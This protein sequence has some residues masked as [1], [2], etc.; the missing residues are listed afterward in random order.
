M[1][2]DTWDCHPAPPHAENYFQ[3]FATF[4]IAQKLCGD[5][6]AVRRGAGVGIIS[7][8][9][10][11]LDKIP[12]DLLPANDKLAGCL[13]EIVTLLTALN[14]PTSARG[15]DFDKEAEV[16]LEKLGVSVR[17]VQEYLDA[18]GRVLRGRQF[19]RTARGLLGFD[20]I[21]TVPGGEVALLIGATVPFVLR[22]QYHRKYRLVGEAYLHGFMHGE[23]RKEEHKKSLVDMCIM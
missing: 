15:K 10:R 21:T 20:P 23:M 6:L 13:G 9:R 4:L 7:E 1:I 11:L 8:S 18:I 3:E 12:S 16:Q 22:T 5:I 14:M 17:K 2:V 19:Y